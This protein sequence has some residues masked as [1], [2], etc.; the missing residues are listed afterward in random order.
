MTLYAGSVKYI[1]ELVEADD[2]KTEAD[3]L[4]A[5]GRHSFYLPKQLLG[6]ITVADTVKDDS[7]SAIAEMR[8]GLEVVMITGDN[9]E[10][11]HA[12]G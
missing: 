10:K 11:L 1:S 5:I 7:R 4:A 9:G 6:M 12:I 2:I 8:Q 3:S